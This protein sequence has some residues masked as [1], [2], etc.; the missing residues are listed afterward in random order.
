MINNNDSN[1]VESERFTTV[2]LPWKVSQKGSIYCMW[3]NLPGD[4]RSQLKQEDSFEMK[5]DGFYYHVKRNGDG[6]CIVFR[7]N[8]AKDNKNGF[9]TG[10]PFMKRPEYRMVEIQ[11]LPVDEANK[12]LASSNQ[13]EVIGSDPIKVVNEQFFAVIGKKEKLQ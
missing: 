3:Q 2:E 1:Q 9:R 7:N 10:Q 4:I 13:F 5:L 12:L 11:I 8:A 6:S